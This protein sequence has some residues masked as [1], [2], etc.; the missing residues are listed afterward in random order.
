MHFLPDPSCSHT[1]LPHCRQLLT[2]LCFCPKHSHGWRP[3]RR[4]LVLASPSSLYSETKCNDF[5]FGGDC[6][7]KHNN[8]VISKGLDHAG[9][10]GCHRLPLPKKLIA[11]KQLSICLEFSSNKVYSTHFPFCGHS[12]FLYSIVLCWFLRASIFLRK[13]KCNL[14]KEVHTPTCPYPVE[15]HGWSLEFRKIKARP[16][17]PWMLLLIVLMG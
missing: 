6:Y 17:C 15:V 14:D 5:F 8:N 7:T 11:N 12:L 16:V 4:T 13:D 1:I 9:M 2:S 10:C 3:G